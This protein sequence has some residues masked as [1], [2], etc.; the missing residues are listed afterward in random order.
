[1]SD[2][3]KTF[4]HALESYPSQDNEEYKPDRAGFKCGFYEGCR[5]AESKISQLGKERAELKARL[6]KSISKHDHEIIVKHALSMG[7]NS[8]IGLEDIAPQTYHTLN[9]RIKNRDKLIVELKEELAQERDIANKVIWWADDS[10][11]LTSLVER[12]RQRIK[13]RKEFEG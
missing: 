6:E 8:K 2:L 13:E 7:D 1:M 10:H 3:H 5:L 9:Q 4:L 11:S 12:A